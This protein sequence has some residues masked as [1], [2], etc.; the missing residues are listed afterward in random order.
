MLLEVVSKM[1]I[2]RRAIDRLEFC[3]P[4]SS[5]MIRGKFPGGPQININQTHFKWD[6]CTDLIGILGQ[7]EWVTVLTERENPNRM[8]RQPP[9]HMGEARTQGD[10]L[11]R[12]SDV[13]FRKIL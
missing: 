4:R 8:D 10:G 3:G 12:L 13:S 2:S 5:V 1:I 11:G 7:V 6:W 9:P